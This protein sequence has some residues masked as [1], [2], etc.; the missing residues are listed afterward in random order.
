MHW[1]CKKLTTKKLFFIYIIIYEIFDR[2][3]KAFNMLI[4]PLVQC[5]QLKFKYFN[6]VLDVSHIDVSFEQF[7]FLF[8]FVLLNDAGFFFVRF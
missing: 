7:L 1:S 8:V 5:E 3:K 4:Q 2:S 6:Q